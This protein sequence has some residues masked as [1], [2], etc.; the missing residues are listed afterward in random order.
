M[1]TTAIVMI[2][3]M[4]EPSPTQNPTTTRAESRGHATTHS[5][6]A[7]VAVFGRP[8]WTTAS[9]AVVMQTRLIVLVC[10]RSAL[11]RL[12]GLGRTLDQTKQ[13]D[14][15][16]NDASDDSAMVSHDSHLL[17]LYRVARP[18]AVTASLQSKE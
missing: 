12:L 5:R 7:G 4:V 2:L 18:A 15:G 10:D 3:M 1:Q 17:Y 6:F 8:A 13:R 16:G 11:R 14:H 9:T